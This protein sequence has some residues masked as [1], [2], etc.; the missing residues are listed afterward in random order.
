MEPKINQIIE[1][2]IKLE[3]E[4]VSHKAELTTLL[5]RMLALKP[6]PV[7]D[8]QFVQDLRR[9]LLSSI[10]AAPTSFES[11]K[12]NFM[13]KIMFSAAALG[14]V[15]VA[16]IAVLTY[17]NQKN[18]K[19]IMNLATQS[20]V[21]I[22]R[23]GSNAFG[24]LATLTS[25]QGLG[26]GG[27]SAAPAALNSSKIAMGMGGSSASD[28][29]YQPTIYNYVYK[30][31]ALTLDSDKLDVLK[32][33]KLDLSVGAANLG[34]FGL[35]LINLD[36]FSGS[37]VQSI[38]FNQDNGYNTYVDLT[39]GMISLYSYSNEIMPLATTDAKLCP[40]DGCPSPQ[41]IDPS[42]IPDDATLISIAQS[43]VDEHG[44]NTAVYGAP[45]V[46]TDQYTVNN[47]LMYAPETINVLYPLKVSD[48]EVFDQSGSKTGLMI[49]IAVR[50]KKVASVWN[51]STREYE[52]SSYDAETDTTKILSIAEKGGIDWYN[53]DTGKKVEVDLG[54]PTIQYVQMWDYNPNYSQE[55]LVPSLIFPILKQ[56]DDNFYRKA[57]VIPLIK[58]ILNRSTNGGGPIKTLQGTTPP[59][60]VK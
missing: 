43:F 29:I 22:T 10:D 16:V 2:L 15:V 60:N 33:Q 32:K 58:D 45:E 40:V 7:V 11:L 44:I 4:F 54:T 50:S 14:V 59:A 34:S 27:G 46:M 47:K 36:S 53:S 19:G 51:L 42:E 39:S 9:K 1:E 56:P 52:A 49:G 13:K 12:S 35:G 3:P 6:E 31:D 41:P 55:I 37:K 57:V 8:A 28:M 38:N 18:G 26:G 48:N 24:S 21:R 17:T 30:G 25:A 23:T 20:A 5:S